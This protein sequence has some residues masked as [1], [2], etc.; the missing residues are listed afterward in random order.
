MNTWVGQTPPAVRRALFNQFRGGKSIFDLSL[1]YGLPFREI[2]RIVRWGIDLMG[3]SAD[4]RHRPARRAVLLSLAK[5][6]MRA[7]EA[8]RSQPAQS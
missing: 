3:R 6:R 2:E 5:G 8:A 7:A 1:D 4:V